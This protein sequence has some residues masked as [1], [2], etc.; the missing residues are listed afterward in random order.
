MWDSKI[1]PNN[2][3]QLNTIGALFYFRNWNITIWWNHRK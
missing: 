2:T 3:E 1:A